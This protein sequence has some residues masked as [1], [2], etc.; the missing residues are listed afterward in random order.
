MK[1][2]LVKPRYLSLSESLYNSFANP[3]AHT[4]IVFREK[5]SMLMKLS[6]LDFAVIG[7]YFVLVLGFLPLTWQ[8]LGIQ[9]AEKEWRSC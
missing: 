7:A 4:A 3:A 6:P 5:P 9:A 8:P 2:D 1:L